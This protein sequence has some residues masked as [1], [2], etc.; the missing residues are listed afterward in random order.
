[1]SIFPI[2]PTPVHQ[3]HCCNSSRTRPFPSL[4]ISPLP[5]G[6]Q[7]TVIC[8]EPMSKNLHGGLP[9][10]PAPNPFVRIPLAFPAGC[11]T[12]TSGLHEPGR[13]RGN[14]CSSSVHRRLL[15]RPTR[16]D[17]SRNS[18]ECIARRIRSFP[19]FVSALFVLTVYNRKNPFFH[20]NRVI[21]A[22]PLLYIYTHNSAGGA[23]CL[24]EECIP[25]CDP[26]AP[27]PLHECGVTFVC[28]R[29]ALDDF[30]GSSLVVLF[31]CIVWLLFDG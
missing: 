4:Q 16:S 12:N 9:F 25:A 15:G 14:T 20:N 29:R 10:P 22:T 6:R 11:E 30:A 2:S 5:N 7:L 31:A 18:S 19:P 27:A 3:C 17:S 24:A 1:M 8:R 23:L 26:A 28:A 21:L 13:R